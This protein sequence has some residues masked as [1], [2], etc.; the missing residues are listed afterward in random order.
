MKTEAKKE[1]KSER[2]KIYEDRAKRDP[3]SVYFEEI[4]IFLIY[5]KAERGRPEGPTK[6]SV[7]KI[8][9]VMLAII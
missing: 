9:F 7:F 3:S 5:S 2:R 4:R 8:N 6:Q 1:R